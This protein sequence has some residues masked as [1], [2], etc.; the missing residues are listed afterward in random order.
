MLIR[1]L[2]KG[3]RKGFITFHRKDILGN[4]RDIAAVPVDCFPTMF[5][6]LVEDLSTDG[7]ASVNLFFRRGHGYADRELFDLHGNRIHRPY[8]RIDAVSRLNAVWADIDCYHHGITEGQAI[9]ALWDAQAEG[10]IPPPSAL[11]SSGRGV[12]VFWFL[13]EPKAFPEH[14]AL[15]RAI[16]RHLQKLFEPIGADASA[17]DAAR[18]CRVAGSLNTKSHNRVNVAILGNRRGVP[19]YKLADLAER[20]QIVLKQTGRRITA[21]PANEINKLKGIKGRAARWQLDESRFW[22]LVKIRE[23]GIREG[24]RHDHVFVLGSIL[25]HRYRDEDQRTKAVD[26]AAARLCRSFAT[27]RG[28]SLSQVTK[29]L[30]RVAFDP[31][32]GWK[33]LKQIAAEE[34]ARRLKITENEA[35]AI[36]ELTSR[37]IHRSW[38]S[39]FGPAP[40]PLKQADAAARRRQWITD[41][42]EAVHRMTRQQLADAL[43]AAGLP[44]SGPTAH[45]DMIS[46]IGPKVTSWDLTGRLAA[47]W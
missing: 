45:K 5:D 30:R 22:H 4:H 14:V 32:I 33:G 25:R 1:E 13:N 21:G 18:I 17:T 27:R 28:Y 3:A 39:M 40:A 10:R 24:T 8:R 34:I 11:Q 15:H 47:D 23:D 29:E 12:W 42:R 37:P 43:T 19:R 41:H 38:P 46:A 26:A 6:E 36:A 16:N 2:V 7:Y 35:Q 44:C 9:G 31:A 20:F